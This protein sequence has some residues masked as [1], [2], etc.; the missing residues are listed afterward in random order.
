MYVRAGCLSVEVFR[1]VRATA[2]AVGPGAAPRRARATHTVKPSPPRGPKVQAGGMGGIAK[3]GG[4]GGEGGNE[5][6]ERVGQ[7]G[8]GRQGE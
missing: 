8:Q 5:G 1:T 2:A 6:R 7:G 3:G 4:E